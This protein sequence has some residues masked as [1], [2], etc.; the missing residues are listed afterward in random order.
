M[1]LE[2]R[3]QKAGD[4][5]S[6]LLTWCKLQVDPE[7]RLGSGPTGAEEIKQHPWFASLDWGLMQVSMA[8][9]SSPAFCCS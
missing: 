9:P 6:R 5:C 7:Q 2:N 3:W 1:L 4:L 8:G